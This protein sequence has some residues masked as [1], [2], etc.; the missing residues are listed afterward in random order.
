MST[1][2]RTLGILVPMAL[3]DA[4][5]P[6]PILGSVL[7]YVLLARPPWFLDLVDDVYGRS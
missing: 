4:I 2:S 5:I 1:R 3:V 6:I 7:I